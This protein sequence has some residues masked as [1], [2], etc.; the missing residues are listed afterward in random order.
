GY[1]CVEAALRDLL[2][3]SGKLLPVSSGD[4]TAV[5]RFTRDQGLVP[6]SVVRAVDSVVALRNMATSDPA[7]VT[8][9]QAAS[10]LALVDALLFALNAQRDR[11]VAG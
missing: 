5:A 2:G 3:A 4:P 8:R 9:D 7:R 1:G 10:F 11:A 6:E